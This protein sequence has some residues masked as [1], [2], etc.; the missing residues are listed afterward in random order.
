MNKQDEIKCLQ[1]LKGDTYFSQVFKPDTIDAM[2][3]NIRL[4]RQIDCLVDMFANIPEVLNLKSQVKTLEKQIDEAKK[5][6]GKLNE[7]RDDW[8]DFLLKA[9]E[10]AVYPMDKEITEKVVAAIGKKEMIRK[11][12]K[13][14]IE[15]SD[16]DKEWLFNNI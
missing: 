10:D 3:E 16:E 1:S 8:M 11:K 4:D 13:L 14:N 7:E 6:I 12:L 5:N 2:C 15:L 9:A